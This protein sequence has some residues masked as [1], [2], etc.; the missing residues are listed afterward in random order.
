MSR[1]RRVK[2]TD[3]NMGRIHADLTTDF[4]NMSRVCCRLARL[5]ALLSAL[6]SVACTP[7]VRLESQFPSPAID[8]LPL[9]A[10]VIYSDEFQDYTYRSPRGVDAVDV[11]LGSA[12]MRLLDRV[13]GAL[14]SELSREETW[15]S[16]NHS[17]QAD[18]VL[19]PKLER[20]TLLHG[21]TYRGKQYCEVRITYRLD[22]YTAEG[23]LVGGL[24][25]KG[26]GR[27]PVGWNSLTGPVR[28][29]TV[30]AMRDA[31]VQ[32][33]L[34][35]P[36]QPAVDQFLRENKHRGYGVRASGYW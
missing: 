19:A 31:A 23:Q 24:P 1:I 17:S 34:Q 2:H 22:L 3:Q 16:E 33:V 25:I 14:F 27:S 10:A 9:R 6:A 18:L 26:Y 32:I 4:G 29:A 21:P 30:R 12:Q 5:A 35:L 28:Q 13:L 20:F 8:P 36:K 7:T 15:P 11:D